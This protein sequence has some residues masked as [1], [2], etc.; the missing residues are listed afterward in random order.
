MCALNFIHTA[1]VIH[2]DIKPANILIDDNCQIFICDFGLARTLPENFEY[3]QCSTAS[4]STKTSSED[5]TSEFQISGRKRPET[6]ADVKHFE[7]SKRVEKDPK[8]CLS[9]HICSRWYRS[10]E[11][12]LAQPKYDFKSDIWGFGCV[13]GEI[14]QVGNSSSET[15]KQARILFPGRSCWP[16]SP[17]K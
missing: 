5:E 7:I 1:N 15:D 12:I 11:L 10:P 3:E 2:R 14:M 8:R 13:L 17:C 9:S 4:L 16:L 6:F